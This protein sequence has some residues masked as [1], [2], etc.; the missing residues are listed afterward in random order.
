M[1]LRLSQYAA[2]AAFAVVAGIVAILMIPR[3]PSI[4]VFEV[5]KGRWSRPRSLCARR[6]PGARSRPVVPTASQ[7]PITIEDEGAPALPSRFDEAMELADRLGL[8]G[9]LFVVLI[10]TDEVDVK[11]AFETKLV[12]AL[13]ERAWFGT[14]EDFG[15]FWAA[16][17][18]V[19][20]DVSSS[21]DRLEA[22]VDVP[23]PVDGLTLR[24]P[25][26]YRVVSIV[27]ANLVRAS[28][29]GLVVLDRFVGQAT[30]VLDTQGRR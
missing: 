18:R 23:E 27:P 13:R 24:L 20:V 12:E 28:E 29:S 21:G 10:H 14:L 2:P 8:Y 6:R 3:Q 26:G 4:V 15:S 16:R 11:L 1:S 5:S 25:S 19:E 9:G 22:V 7:F 17:H 30:L